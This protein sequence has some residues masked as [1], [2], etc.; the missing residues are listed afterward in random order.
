MYTDNK[1]G[2]SLKLLFEAYL[3]SSQLGYLVAE[4]WT[5]WNTTR[6]N[7]FITSHFQSS[8]CHALTE[9]YDNFRK[10]I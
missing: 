3:N 4:A 8:K 10:A 7:K 6:T 2:V 1:F 9:H 5:T